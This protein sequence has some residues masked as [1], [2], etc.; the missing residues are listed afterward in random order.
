MSISS[1]TH[2]YIFL[3]YSWLLHTENSCVSTAVFPKI[4][5]DISKILKKFNCDL[6][7]FPLK[8]VKSI[9]SNSSKILRFF[10]VELLCIV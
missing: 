6:C 10:Q 5:S 2:S 3:K 4:K 8:G 1:S 9:S 7:A